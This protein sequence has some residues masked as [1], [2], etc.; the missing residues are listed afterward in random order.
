MKQQL[1][2]RRPSAHNPKHFPHKNNTLNP[3]PPPSFGAMPSLQDY[4]QLWFFDKYLSIR[5]A[6]CATSIDIDCI[7]TKTLE[8]SMCVCRGPMMPREATRRHARKSMSIGGLRSVFANFMRWAS[9]RYVATNPVTRGNSPS[10]STNPSVVGRCC[11][12]PR[13]R[14]LGG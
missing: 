7:T 3:H 4:L 2:N 14:S 1:P 8:L 6:N 9:G 11:G 13:C 5:R 12:L 10:D